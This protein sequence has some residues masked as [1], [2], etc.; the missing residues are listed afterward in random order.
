MDKMQDINYID[1]VSL[2][3]S[4]EWRSWVKFLKG[5]MSFMYH[6]AINQLRD[7]DVDGSKLSVAVADDIQKQI[8]TFLDLINKYQNQR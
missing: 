7:G 5:R 4:Q 1:G 8:D 2:I 3:S 6:K